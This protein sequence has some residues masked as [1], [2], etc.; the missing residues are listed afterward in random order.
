MYLRNFI[1]LLWLTRDALFYNMNDALDLLVVFHPPKNE[2]SLHISKW[3]VVG[4]HLAE[5]KSRAGT[6]A[7]NHCLCVLIQAMRARTSIGPTTSNS[8][9]LKLLPR[10]AFLRWEPR[11]LVA[12]PWACRALLCLPCPCGYHSVLSLNPNE[13]LAEYNKIVQG[14]KSFTTEVNLLI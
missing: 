12:A 3:E 4:G 11:S 1:I 8:V 10:G 2:Q 9:V 5:W 6:W 13:H 14:K 7:V